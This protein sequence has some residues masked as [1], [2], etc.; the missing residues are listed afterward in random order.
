MELHNDPL[1]SSQEVQLGSSRDSLPV[2]EHEGELRGHSMERLESGEIPKPTSEFQ[3]R[4]AQHNSPK[5]QQLLG[6]H[7]IVS[8][9]TKSKLLKTGLTGAII[10]LAMRLIG[11]G[12]VVEAKKLDAKMFMEATQAR[13]LVKTEKHI[14]D[15]VSITKQFT[16]AKNFVRNDGMPMLPEGR[17]IQSFQEEFENRK[18][19]D[20]ET[21]ARAHVNTRV[22]SG[23]IEALESGN[24]TKWHPL[25]IR[26]VAEDEFSVKENGVVPTSERALGVSTDLNN[27]YVNISDKGH[28]TITTGIINTQDRAD[29]FMQAIAKAVNM[30]EEMNTERKENGLPEFGPLKIRISSHSLNAFGVSK[31][32]EASMIKNQNKMM[33][34]VDRNLRGVL[35]E[36][37]YKGI[38]PE[39]P[40]VSHVN[41]TFNGFTN[42]PGEEAKCHNMSRPG[43]ATQMS[44]L[45]EDMN[46]QLEGLPEIQ[47]NLTEMSVLKDTIA[48]LE[49]GT[50]QMSL[51]QKQALSKR[52][53]AAI[54]NRDDLKTEIEEADDPGYKAAMAAPL[55]QANKQIQ[56]MQERLT[57]SDQRIGNCKAKLETHKASLKVEMKRLARAMNQALQEAEQ[58]SDIEKS[59]KLSVGL[60]ILGQQLEMNKE[61]GL[62]KLNPGA[63]I[64]MML[65]LDRINGATTQSNCKSSLDRNSHARAT[66]PVL[67]QLYDT[68]NVSSIGNAYNFIRDFESDVKLMD[69]NWKE[70]L[71]AHKDE[72]GFE[73]DWN[74]FVQKD[75]QYRQIVDFQAKMFGEMMGVGRPITSWST[76]TDGGFKWHH[77]KKTMNPLEKNRHPMPYIPAQIWDE[78]S[79]KMVQ[80]VTTDKKGNR[81]FTPEGLAL[82]AGQSQKRGA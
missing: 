34:Y 76:G 20:K 44:W 42:V 7:K 39:R 64:Q 10:R 46:L 78:D 62:S 19:L 47:K 21:V 2:I 52:L 3:A 51:D 13:E 68:D 63:E 65:L 5:V 79:Q 43:I 24:G 41:R 32:G 50:G 15:Q 75:S 8:D 26:K 69:N 9:P 40:M 35:I 66:G 70:H 72:A 55:A 1:S 57:L 14:T 18:G 53:D 17:G 60:H 58:K 82:Y 33:D 4:V 49:A 77:D 73:P 80:L 59:T 16:G 48:K 29:E 38:M 74:A 25:E 12:D 30:R 71:K 23:N 61:L 11:K 67:D 31:L 36:S 6:T 22:Y 56:E 45:C 28:L 27:V 54:L 37:G 81:E